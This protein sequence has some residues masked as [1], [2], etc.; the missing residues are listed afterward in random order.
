MFIPVAHESLRGRRW[1]WVTVG[2][3]V[4]N[5]VVFFATYGRLDADLAQVG[6]VQLHLL[7]LA[8]H[9][10][11]A[12]ITGDAARMV[13]TFKRQHPKPYANLA[14]ARPRAFDAWDAQMQQ[15]KWTTTDIQ[16]QAMELSGKFDALHSDSLA[17]N[18]AFHSYHPTIR[19]FIT[20]QFL[21]AGWL[22]IIFNMWFLWLAGTILE[23]AW[24][25]MVYP[26]FYLVTGVFSWL[27]QGVVFPDSFV[28]GVG[29]SG[30]IAGLMGAFLAR[31]PTVKIKLMWIW[32]FGLVRAYKLVPAYVILPLWLVIQVFWGALAASSGVDAG[33]AYWAHIGGF[34]FGMIGAVILRSTGLEHAA[35]Q[36]IEAKVSLV[37]DP[38]IVR[39]SESIGGD[40]P[41]AAIPE[42][43]QL[44]AD[45][46]D[47]IDG[48]ELLLRAYEKK[49]DLEGEK[50]TLATLCRLN[51]ASGDLQTA[52]DYYEQFSNLGGEKISRGVWMELCRWL[53]SQSN[54]DRAAAQYKRV[55]EMNPTERVSVQ[56]LM[57]A[58]RINI[59]RLNRPSEAERLFRLAEASPVAHEDQIVMIEDGLK[60]CAAAI[61]AVGKYSS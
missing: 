27:V 18:Y 38:R 28:V 49:Q 59:E 20:A 41:D 44:V 25:R 17:W 39:A 42:L 13:A 35:D 2:I 15:G 26:I 32:G 7:L 50:E 58:A 46:P 23:D 6:Q 9:Y 48:H 11:D 31:F 47:S 40:K 24:G 12:P 5:F 10:P 36:A 57:A 29:A 56:A 37:V 53:E 54:W 22:H 14:A 52:W 45:K 1:P 51:V 21:H 3:I 55:A 8:A 43:K 61:P 33:V 60:K 30:A 19:S 16:S 34:A 4:I